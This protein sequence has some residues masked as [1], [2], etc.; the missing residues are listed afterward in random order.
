MVSKAC[1]LKDSNRAFTCKNEHTR[2][3]TPGTAYLTRK[4]YLQLSP[5][6]PSSFTCFSA[7]QWYSIVHLNNIFSTHPSVSRH[8]GWVHFLAVEDK[9]EVQRSEQV[10]VCTAQSALAPF[11][12]G[13]GGLEMSPMILGHLNICSLGVCCLEGLGGVTLQGEVA[14][15]GKLEDSKALGHPQ[16]AL[17]TSLFLSSMWTLSCSC[18]R[19]FTLILWTQSSETIAVEHCFL[20]ALVMVSHHSNRSMT[21]TVV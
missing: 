2:F 15:G 8:L 5:C 6:F 14:T 16:G 21:K 20:S 19:A 13:C 7:V 18:S 12:S 10:S 9:E 4:D 3:V 1:I 17:H 11:L